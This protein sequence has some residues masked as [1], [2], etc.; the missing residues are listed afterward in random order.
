[1]GPQDDVFLNI[2][3]IDVLFRHGASAYG[4]AG[5]VHAFRIA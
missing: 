2:V 5:G 1:M 3:L 4:D